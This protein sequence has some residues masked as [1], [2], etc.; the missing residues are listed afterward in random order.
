L[1][2]GTTHSR[3]T[4]ALA[5]TSSVLTYYF[6][7]GPAEIIAV[8]GGVLTGLVLTPDLDVDIGCVSK[9]IVRQSAGRVPAALWALFW[10]PYGRMMPHRSHLSHLPL[11]GTTIRLLYIAI[12]PALLFWFTD[13]PFNRPEIPIWGWWAFGGLV[14][15]DTLHYLMDRIF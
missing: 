6:G 5:F 15:A 14:L 12:L 2:R 1:P 8:T 13:G 11:V 3:A 4:V 9:N 10:L 7:H